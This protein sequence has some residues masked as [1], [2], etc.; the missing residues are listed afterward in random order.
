MSYLYENKFKKINKRKMELIVILKLIMF[1]YFIFVIFL[2]MCF[3]LLLF[4]DLKKLLKF[5]KEVCYCSGKE[6]YWFCI[7]V[8]NIGLVENGDM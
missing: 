4:Y 3:I 8:F 6:Y 5:V 1:Y 7:L 2:I